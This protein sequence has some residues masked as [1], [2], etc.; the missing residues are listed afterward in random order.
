MMTS[1]R[2]CTCSV[3]SLEMKILALVGEFLAGLLGHLRG[4]H[5]A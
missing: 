3:Q 5:T 1:I 4:P 2:P